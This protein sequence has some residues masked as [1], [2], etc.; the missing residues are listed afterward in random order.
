VAFALAAFNS[1]RLSAIYFFNLFMYCVS[2]GDLHFAHARRSDELSD[3]KVYKCVVFNPHLDLRAGGS[4][5]RIS[6]QPP[7]GGSTYCYCLDMPMLSVSC[8][9]NLTHA[10]VSNHISDIANLSVADDEVC[11][12]CDMLTCDVIQFVSFSHDENDSNHQNAP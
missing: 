4:Y 11:N 10:T 3:D 7:R 1:L 5:T 8:Y 9:S 2:A 12:A 6:V